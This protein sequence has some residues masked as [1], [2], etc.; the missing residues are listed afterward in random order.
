M[1]AT[2]KKLDI[3][4]DKRGWL[5]E[6]LRLEDISGKKFGQIFI[7][8][9]H[10]GEKKGQHYHKRKTEWYCVIKGKALLT[11]IDK[12]SGEKDAVEMGEE[13]M[14]IVKIYPNSH[15]TIENIGK[16]DMYLVVYID[17]PFNPLDADTYYD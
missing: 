9:A 15:H 14:I 12:A 11:L 8:V 4:K 6:V 13:N 1:R 10:P 2:I 17:E 3:K 5:M 7:S 16:E